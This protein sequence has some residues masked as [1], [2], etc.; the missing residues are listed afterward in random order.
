MAIGD[1]GSYSKGKARRKQILEAALTIIAIDGFNQ[2]TLSK[3]S[4]AV[5]ITDVG[6]LHYFDS[7]DDLM[8][9]A[10]KQRDANDMVSAASSFPDFASRVKQLI[11]HPEQ[12]IKQVMEIVKRNSR[13]PGLVELYAHMSVKASDP[14]SPAHRYFK[15]RGKIE[16]LIVG[17]AA[18]KVMEKEKMQT[19]LTPEEMARVMQV[20]L[21]GL[22][23][24]WLLDRDV[25]MA[26]IAGKA[27]NLM[28]NQAR[29]SSESEDPNGEQDGEQDDE[30]GADE[31]P[32][33]SYED[34]LDFE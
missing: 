12:S 9:Q 20:L 21:D 33:P 32:L 3:I 18:R 28:W 31:D 30:E 4:K 6:V 22:Q 16:R 25:D 34:L 24:Q 5:G 17:H 14:T 7:M 23:I 27:I 2:T 1:R 8:V 15:Q 13:T 29:H 11:S 10:L 26:D 19:D